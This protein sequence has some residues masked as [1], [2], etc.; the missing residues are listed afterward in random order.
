MPGSFSLHISSVILYLSIAA[1]SF[2]PI[3]PES[4]EANETRTNKKENTQIEYEPQKPVR[5]EIVEIQTMNMA[6]KPAINKKPVKNEIQT[7]SDNTLLLVEKLLSVSSAAKHVQSSQ[8]P[9]AKQHYDQ[10]KQYL[11]QAHQAQTKGDK[12]TR[13][14]TI[15]LAKMALFKAVQFADKPTELEEKQKKDIQNR[16]KNIT[17]LLDAYHRISPNSE[18]NTLFKQKLNDVQRI[19]KNKQLDLAEKKAQQLFVDIKLALIDLRNGQTLVH[20]LN[21][22]NPADEYHYEINRNNSHKMLLELFGNQNAKL[23]SN[24]KVQ[25]HIE[26]AIKL[27]NQAEQSA[28]ENAYQQGIKLL[29]KSTK[30]YIRAIQATGVYVPG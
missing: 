24:S 9:L 23:V 17:A 11:Q 21:F 29:E 25:T 15:S 1:C 13:D 18:K 22:A 7:S 14:K 19:F 28:M 30:Q 6:E 27:R 4:T 12:F 16:I 3:L 20:S 5:V 8:N 2:Q 10:A 26:Q